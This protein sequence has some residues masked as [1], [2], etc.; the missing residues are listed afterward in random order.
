MGE[1]AVAVVAA[2]IAAGSLVVAGLQYLLARRKAATESDRL[3]S[4]AE[5]LRTAY[6]AAQ[7]AVQ[8]M[9]LI[10][11]RAKDKDATIVELQ[12][13]ARL[14]RGTLTL[15]AD[16]LDTETRQVERQERS[17]FLRTYPAPR[18]DLDG[19]PDVVTGPN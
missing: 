6:T 13:L 12:N 9:N 14:A 8:S 2:T 3:A 17:H 1:L 5:R 19:A 16:H 7:A 18:K 11:Q 4:Q 15:L 10:V